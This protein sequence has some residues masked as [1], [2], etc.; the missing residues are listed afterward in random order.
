MAEIREERHAERARIIAYGTDNAVRLSESF[1]DH[2]SSVLDA[3]DEAES[4]GGAA[5]ALTL[6][7]VGTEWGKM[8]LI[9]EELAAAI[10]MEITSRSPEAT[11]DHPLQ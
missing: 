8:D 3:I 10:R 6:G 11:P 4:A 5:E 9:F 2:F 1:I 7:N